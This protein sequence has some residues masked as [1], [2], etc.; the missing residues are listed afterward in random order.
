MW[1]I[2]TDARNDF[3]RC[4]LSFVGELNRL[5]LSYVEYSRGSCA[6]RQAD[7]RGGLDEL[8]HAKV[9]SLNAPTSFFRR[10]IVPR[11]GNYGVQTVFQQPVQVQFELR[12]RF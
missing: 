3:C 8:K 11:Q 4:G 9:Q 1:R 10:D 12:L 5:A 2:A 7:R 6:H